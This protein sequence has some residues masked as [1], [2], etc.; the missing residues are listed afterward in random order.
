MGFDPGRA[1]D[2]AMNLAADDEVEL[3]VFCIGS[4]GQ[5]RD[6]VV[7]SKSLVKKMIAAH[8]ELIINRNASR[9]SKQVSL[10]SDSINLTGVRYTGYWLCHASDNRIAKALL[11]KGGSPLT[12]V[13]ADKTNEVAR[14]N[15]ELIADTGG[16]QLVIPAELKDFANKVFAFIEQAK[17]QAVASASN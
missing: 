6:N 10:P 14:I 17:V 8:P 15:K 7:G 16:V 9:A 11:A 5:I 1:K 4:V 12:G 13:P 2:L 3:A